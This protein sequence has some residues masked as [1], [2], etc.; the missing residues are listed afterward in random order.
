MIRQKM[1]DKEIPKGYLYLTDCCEDGKYNRN[2]I[3][4]S[5]DKVVMVKKNDR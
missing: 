3:H 5:I 2:S 4:M 1:A